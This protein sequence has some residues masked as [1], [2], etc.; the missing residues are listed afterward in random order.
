MVLV[1]Q[2]HA[3][4]SLQICSCPLWG[5][6]ELSAV[7]V[8]LKVCLI[9][10]VDTELIAQIVPFHGIRVMTGTDGIEVQAFHDGD[11]FAHL[12]LGNGT[13]CLSA[14]IVTVHTT[15]DKAFA[16]QGQNAA[17]VDFHLTEA[18][19]AALD[20]NGFVL[21]VL[22]LYNQRIECR[23]FCCPECRIFYRS[24]YGCDKFRHQIE[25]AFR[26]RFGNHL[27]YFVLLCIIQGYFCVVL[28][29]QRFGIVRPDRNGKSGFRVI[30]VG[31]Q[32]LCFVIQDVLHRFR[33]EADIAVNAGQMPV[34]LILEIRTVT[35]AHHLYGKGIR[36]FFHVLCDIELSV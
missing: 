22:Q 24:S 21:F 15:D 27:G 35:V 29:V 31:K 2:Y 10:K 25:A 36:S 8:C 17:A 5:C 33:Y 13:S 1:T 14:E 9:D 28:A 11:L 12:L 3:G 20:I 23:G 16:V 30:R 6:T 18:D 7:A 26:E 32:G 19:F 34:I 4:C